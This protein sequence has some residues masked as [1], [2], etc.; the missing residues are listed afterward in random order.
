MTILNKFLWACVPLA[1]LSACGGGDTEDRLDVADPAVRFVHA[2][3]AAPAVTLY[4]DTVAQPDATNTNFGFASNYFDV[5]VSAADWS[6]KTSASGANVATVNIDPKRGTKY[7]IVAL[8]TSATANGAYVITDPYNKPLSSDSTHLRV[9][10]GAYNAGGVD[11]YMNAP[12]TD[13]TAAG[14]N[15]LIAAIAVNTAGPAS[16]MDSV[17]IPGG[18][19]QVTI[20]VAG[21]KTVIF[22]GQVG[23]A[24]NKD[25]LLLTVPSVTP[26][27]VR[28]LLKTEGTAGTTEIPAGT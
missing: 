28:V 25:L 13:I 12:G 5:A 10:N 23:F 16:G 27:A 6:V 21:T 17:D 9:M 15:P 7:T 26:G 11:V 24:S 20:T 22:R 1:A 14:I 4:R 19:Y 8:N 2:A 18:T 3:P